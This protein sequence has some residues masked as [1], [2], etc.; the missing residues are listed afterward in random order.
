MILLVINKSNCCKFFKIHVMCVWWMWGKTI[1]KC[2]AFNF[3]HNFPLLKDALRCWIWYSEHTSVLEII[4]SAQCAFNFKNLHGWS[5]VCNRHEYVTAS[6]L[7]FLHTL[8]GHGGP[9]Q[10]NRS[11]H[12]IA[13]RKEYFFAEIL[14]INQHKLAQ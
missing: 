2:S 6:F 14:K 10:R 7:V 4:H 8:S 1:E 13:R 5:C 3:V 9:R 11:K 12:R